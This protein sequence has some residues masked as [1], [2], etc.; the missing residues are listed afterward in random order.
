ME[1][2][3]GVESAKVSLNEGRATIQLNAGNTVSMSQIRQGV[4]RNGFTPQQ[5]VINAQA[6]VIAAGNRLQLKISGTNDTYDVAATA[7]AESI[8]QQ[9]K[10][11]GGQ[12][13]LI[14]G[15]IPVQKDPKAAPVIQ[16]NSVKP[17]TSASAR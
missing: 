4:E 10:K 11:S 13:V 12:K 16:V 14:E 1:K 7:H 5:A 6:D 3:P 17:V 2:L 9:L 8:Q 15:I